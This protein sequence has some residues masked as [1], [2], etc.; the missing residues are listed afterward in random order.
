[1]SSLTARASRG[2]A[3]L[4]L[5][6]LGVSAEEPR[7][8][9][10]LELQ[11]TRFVEVFNLLDQKLADPID[12]ADAVYK[13]AIPA[14]LRNLD[15]HSAF[16]DPQQFEN[17]KEMQ[18]ATEKGFGIV[19]NLLP[20]RVIVL[21]TIEDSPSARAG[22]ASG[23]ELV[24]ANGYPLT[25]MPVEQL[26]SVLSESRND[27]AQFMVKRPNFT[28]LIPMTLVPV[29]MA[30]PSVSR[31]FFIE[32]GLAY[33]KVINFEANTAQELHD[34]IESM[35]GRDLNGFI[36]DLRGNPGGIVEVAVQ[37]AASF[38]NERERILWIAS[39]SGP[40]E[41]LTVP[42]GFE[43]YRFPVAVLVDDR[44]ASAAELVTG[45]LQDH[46]RATVIGDR[47]YG[48]GLVQSVFEL[49]AKAGLALTTAYY[50][51]PD[52]HTI[53]RSLGD[54]REY[55]LAPCDDA[56]SE[57]ER[58]GGIKPDQVVYPAQL[59]ELETVLKAS[60]SFLDF[61]R[62]SV[63]GVNSIDETFEPSNEMLDNFQLYLSE[64]GIRPTL[65]QWS[66][67]LAFIRANL[68]QEVLNLTVGVE[69]GDEVELRRDPVVRAAVSTIKA[70]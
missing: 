59:S 29:E 1:M 65:S 46:G 6:A 10:Q 24:I 12:P 58:R 53:Q 42:E 47:S 25:Q 23:D 63:R 9:H 27:R 54:C 39:R 56:R 37:V 60:N 68:K 21:Q 28:R 2:I 50:L 33:V 66:T 38:L 7:E 45:A 20:G 43:P 17:L 4:A 34:A 19:A 57:D 62:D 5:A 64:R 3:F 35:G 15:P 32:P 14:M 36:I 8:P 40:K 69:I 41:E 48:K 52:E 18:R 30:D 67:S 11:L 13:G 44:T 70:R 22:I 16:L 26:V 31:H 55:Q 49:S 61:A 51:T